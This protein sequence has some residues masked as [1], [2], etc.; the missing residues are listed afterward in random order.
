MDSGS[1][2]LS[3]RDRVALRVPAAAKTAV[4]IIARLPPH[5]AVRRYALA[6]AFRSAS[7][8]MRVGRIETS[9][10]MFEPNVEYRLIGWGAATGLQERYVGHAGILAVFEDWTN[11]LGAPD[12]TIEDV[13][14]TGDAVFATATLR[15][16]GATSG[17][18]IERPVASIFRLSKR[19][20]VS[21]WDSY[22]NRTDAYE[23]VGLSP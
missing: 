20:R 18:I 8:I 23:A 5:S 15:A 10:W 7:N 13:F 3:I 22:W 21:S 11:L 19:G 4:A 9:L 12:F 6:L 2:G 1:R 17:A 14:E 16:R